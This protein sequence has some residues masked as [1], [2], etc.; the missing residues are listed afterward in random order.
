MRQVFDS[1]LAGAPHQ[2]PTAY[3]VEHP[4][5]YFIRLFEHA[6]RHRQFYKLMLDG[7][8]VSRFHRL[9]KDYIVD[10]ASPGQTAGRGDQSPKRTH[11]HAN[12]RAMV[13]SATDF[14]AYRTNTFFSSSARSIP[15]L[16]TAG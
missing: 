12:T 4:A 6:A 10:L 13:S 15:P 1:L 8:G 9:I 14:T 5:S 2:P 11:C 3:S 16:R 7:E